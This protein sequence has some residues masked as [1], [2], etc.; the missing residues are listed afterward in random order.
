MTAIDEGAVRAG[1]RVSVVAVIWT[2]ATGVLS[3]G[4]GAGRGSLALVAFG[5]IGMLDALGSATL[6]VHFRHTL[7][8]EA[9]SERHERLALRVINLGM[10]VIGLSTVIESTRRLVFGAHVD[11]VWAG[12]VLAAVSVVVLAVLSVQKRRIGHQIPSR[13]LQADGALSAIGAMLAFVTTVGAGI[14]SFGDAS[15]VDPSAAVVVG[16]I[17]VVVA[18]RSTRRS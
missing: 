7:H 16:L 5:S 3:I 2:V 8:H 1:L 14:A 6:V 12:V 18:V 11:T 15:S 4:I 17:A 10:F 13:A 9:F